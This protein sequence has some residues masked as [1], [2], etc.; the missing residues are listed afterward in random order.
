VRRGHDKLG[1]NDARWQVAV[2]REAIIRPLANAGPLSP[3]DVATACRVLGLRRSRLYA[4]IDQYRHAPVTSSLA[5]A[6]PGPKRGSRRLCV[7]METLIEEAIHAKYLT[8][9]KA[10]VSKLHDH[11]RHLCR[12][13]GV[14]IPSWKAV[15]ARVGEIDR[16]RLVSQREGGKAA[17]DRLRPVTQEY[18]ADH[19]LHI[20]QIDH[21]RV[22]LFVVDAIYRRPIQRPWL[23]LAIDVASR[24]VVGFYLSLEA[25]SSASVAL[26][27]HHAVLPKAAWLAARGIGLDWP[28]SGLPDIVHVDNAREFRGRALARG[29]A[30]Y[31]ISLIHRPV[32]TPHYGGHIE[33]LIGTMMGAVHMLPGT[34]F[35]TI[36]ERG[37]YDPERHAVM[38]LD[39][40]ER[41]LTLEIV[42]RYHNEVHASLHMPPNAAWQDAADRRGAPFRH[43]HDER[44]FLY[45]FLPFE[46]RSIRR[47]GLHLFGLRYWDDVLSPWAGRLDRRLRVK[48]DPRDLSCVFV[49]GPDG[50]HWPIRY[51]DL[52][53]PRITLGEHRLALSALRQRGLRLTD[54]Q[55]IF[56][57]VEAQRQL[58]ETAASASKSARRQVDRRARALNATEGVAADALAPAPEDEPETLPVLAVEEWS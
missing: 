30:E 12:E 47:D 23:T 25:P 51:A 3:V 26:V 53:R 20:V 22:D 17:R 4:L 2:T 58:V 6:T 55:L 48:Y 16:F 37:D 10:S 44:Q 24:M 9:Q 5:S 38:T 35:S 28:V 57:T 36:A 54:E 11:I 29:A 32:A 21:T 15:R 1:I 33:R 46:E 41:W 52:R 7:E 39:E 40:L 56:D 27:M 14:R 49:E 19:A 43:P 13:R 8:R 42:G 50:A 18:R 34:T 45:D 31:G